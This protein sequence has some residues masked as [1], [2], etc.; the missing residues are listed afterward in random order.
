MTIRIREEIK[1]VE[2][3]WSYA[4]ELSSISSRGTNSSVVYREQRVPRTSFLRARR[5]SQEANKALIVGN[6]NITNRLGL[7]AV[8]FRRSAAGLTRL[9]TLKYT[10]SAH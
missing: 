5:A 6:S 10:A 4:T 7:W 1:F 9:V 3:G 8:R 2:R